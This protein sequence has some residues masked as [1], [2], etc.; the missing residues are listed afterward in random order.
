MPRERDDD[1]RDRRDRNDDRGRGRDREDDRGSRKSSERP[2]YYVR[3]SAE[4]RKRG[5]QKGGQYDSIFAGSFPVFSPKEGSYRL[6]ILPR[7]WEGDASGS[8]NYGLDVHVHFGIG[9]DEETYVCLAKMGKG[10]CPVCE[11][12][13]DANKKGDEEYAKQLNVSRRVCCWVVDRDNEDDG[14]MLWAMPWTLDRDLG[15]LSDDKRTGETVAMED[16]D[17]GYDIEFTREGKG[18]RTK[19]TGIQI[20][21]KSSPL[22]DDV[23]VADKWLAFAAD[24]PV[25]DCIQYFDYE[26]IKARFEGTARKDNEDEDKGGSSRSAR[27]RLRDEE[28]DKPRRGSRLRDEEEEAPP[29]RRGR[30][31]EPPE[32]EEENDKPPP[33]RGRE[34]P[35]EDEPEDTPPPR[36][37]RAE[38]EEEEEEAPSRRGRREEPKDEEEDPPSRRRAKLDEPEEDEPPA[39]GKR[40]AKETGKAVGSRLERLRG[41]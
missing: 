4:I 40:D 14:P 3:S 12:R 10:D 21:R 29:P 8:N 31:E 18:T 30:R 22:H 2:R 24:N 36:R 16:P 9:P 13:V 39:R 37:G 7:T 1:R 15:L 20:A 26:Y 25:P 38:P 23:E 41:K 35:E 11:E 27:S 32:D 28:D 33:R 5:Q 34:E 6:R 19:Y 17:E